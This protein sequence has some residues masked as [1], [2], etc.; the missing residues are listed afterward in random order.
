MRRRAV[1]SHRRTETRKRMHVLRVGIPWR[2]IGSKRER[3]RV[4]RSRS[5]GE[6]SGRGSHGVIGNDGDVLDPT[7]LGRMRRVR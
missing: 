1:R 7:L 5:R 2:R 3:P 6:V 4:A